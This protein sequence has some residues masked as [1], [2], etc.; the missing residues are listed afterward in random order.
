M[1]ASREVALHTGGKEMQYGNKTISFDGKNFLEGLRNTFNL[2]RIGSE[3]IHWK[4]REWV[5][6]GLMVL[7]QVVAFVSGA[8]WSLMGWIGLATG[9]FTILSLI[10]VDRGRI[11]NYVWGFLGSLVWLIIAI[12]NHLVGDMFSQTFY[13]VMQFVG[14][15]AWQKQLSRQKD[16]ENTEVQPKKMTTLMAVLSIIGTIVIYAI[17][18]T[19]SIHANGNQVWLDGTLLPLGIIGQILMTYGFRSQW[20]AWIALDVVN[21]IIWVNQLQAGGAAA[22]SMLVLQIVMTVNALYG[23]WLWFRPVERG[24]G[25][26]VLESK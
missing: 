14:I 5:L 12:E 4:T 2:K 11:T 21:V 23:C 13:V 10:L 15:Y 3:L 24:E 19:V 6:L 9:V 26:E 7:A 25:T 8:D 16:G 17:V 1:A 20:I 22:L 18:V